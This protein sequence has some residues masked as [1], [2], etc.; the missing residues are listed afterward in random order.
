MPQLLRSAAKVAGKV[1]DSKH[2]TDNNISISVPDHAVGDACHLALTG[3]D[4]SDR[5]EEVRKERNTMRLGKCLKTR[6]IG[7]TLAK[8]PNKSTKGLF[9]LMLELVCALLLNSCLGSSWAPFGHMLAQ[10]GALWHILEHFL[11]IILKKAQSHKKT[12]KHC[13]VVNF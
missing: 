9:E 7:I 5:I 3:T 13:T 1:D 8:H 10:V 2:E 6:L 4:L 12:Q 11:S